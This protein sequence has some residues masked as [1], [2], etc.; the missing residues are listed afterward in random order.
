MS[1]AENDVRKA[2]AQE[3]DQPVNNP[4]PG[5]LAT[6][7]NFTETFHKRGTEIERRYEDA[8]D[9]GSPDLSMS[10]QKANLFFSNVSVIKESLFNSLPKPDVRRLHTGEWDND[11]ARVAA[12]II[13]RTLTYEIKKSPGFEESIKG[14][15]FDR[16]V[17]GIGTV[18]VEFHEAKDG[19]PEYIT[20]EPVYWKDLVWEPQRV[21]RYCD[22]VGRK[23]TMSNADAEARWPGKVNINDNPVSKQVAGESTVDQAILTDKTTVIQMW[24]RLNK[25]M[26]WITC[27]GRLL[28]E[29]NDPYGIPSFY[30][31]PK[32]LIA[33]QVT[34]KFLPVPDYY[35]AQDQYMQIDTLYARIS[36]IIKAVRVAGVYDSSNPS[37]GRMLD[38]TENTLIPVD[39]WAMFAERGGLKGQIDWF[40]VETITQV[41]NHLTNAYTFVKGELFEVTGMADIVRGSSNQYETASAQQIKAQFASV[42]LNGFQRDVSDHVRDVLN[43][44]AEIQITLYSEE[45]MS[46]VCGILPEEDQKYVKDALAMLKTNFKHQASIDIEA[47]SLTQADWGL[48]QQQRL[49]YVQALSGFIQSALPAAE[50]TPE[51]APLL[52]AIIKFASV[53]FKGSAELEGIL[54]NSLQNLLNKEPEEEGP[55]PEMQK[56]QMEMQQMQAK[57]QADQQKMQADLMKMQEEMKLKQQEASQGMQ[58]DAAKHQQEMQLKQAE[59]VQKMEEMREKHSLQ[60]AQL[61]EKMEMQRQQDRIKAEGGILKNIASAFKP[62]DKE[63][64]DA[65]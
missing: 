44:I 10:L 22:W 53:G 5:R 1:T 13:E 33:N 28:E 6:F 57:A 52:I 26:L 35:I 9:D 3:T 8:R 55:S 48:E 15:I 34:R 12:L 59:F 11:V 58:Q 19:A 30:P 25:R 4:W 32:P 54:D 63:K 21:W 38:G 45:R 27:E 50:S 40:P 56:M 46:Q 2:I 41:L 49:A 39:N 61:E 18:W 29:I 43:I 64:K 51:L 16:L 42:R 23:I 62:K 14:S 17:P 31:T 60:M 20:V 37:I 36:L 7:K 47:D 24:D 65:K